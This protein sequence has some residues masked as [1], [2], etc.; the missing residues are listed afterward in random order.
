LRIKEKNKMEENIILTRKEF[1]ELIRIKTRVEA[2][3]DVIANAKYVSTDT[4]CAMLGIEV[5]KDA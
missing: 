1:M 2:L 5:N 3:A 4:I